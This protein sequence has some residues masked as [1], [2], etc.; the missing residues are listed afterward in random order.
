MT[1]VSS[2]SSLCAPSCCVKTRCAPLVD[3]CLLS[4]VRRPPSAARVWGG[5]LA[6]AEH[7]AARLPQVDLVL[8]F[9]QALGDENLSRAEQRK[10]KK[11]LAQQMLMGQGD[12]LTCAISMGRADMRP[13]CLSVLSFTTHKY[14][15]SRGHI[16]G[17][18]HCCR[19]KRNHHAATLFA[20]G[21]LKYCLPSFGTN[22]HVCASSRWP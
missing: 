6:A 21:A 20:S 7:F 8:E 11:N 17:W 3:T 13:V 10:N 22:A 9:V 5:L 16:C 4:H 18:L 2:S 1:R 19:E 14:Q 15:T 12:A